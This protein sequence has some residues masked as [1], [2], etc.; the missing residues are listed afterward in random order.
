MYQNA[1]NVWKI[2]ISFLQYN[3][4]NINMIKLFQPVEKL[5]HIIHMYC[6]QF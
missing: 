3:I 2:Q 4:N 1:G 6:I 5:L